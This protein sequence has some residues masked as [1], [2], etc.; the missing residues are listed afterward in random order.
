MIVNFG[1]R[2][3]DADW[4]AF[5]KDGTLIAFEVMWG[6]LA[7]AWVDRL[8]GG[9]GQETLWQE[10]YDSLGYDPVLQ[11][12]KPQSPLAIA[13]TGELHTIMA[14]TLYRHGVSWPDAHERVRLAMEAGDELALADLVEPAGDV[15]SLFA[16][17]HDAGVRVAVVTTDARADT[18]ETLRLLGVERLVDSVVC[19]DDGLVSKPAPD[20]LHAASEGLGQDVIRC[21]V[22]G[23]TLGDLGMAERA[24]A[25][26]RVAVLTGA[27]D[28]TILAQ[29]A[30]V[31]LDSIDD[32]SVADA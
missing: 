24:G 22:V 5:D 25:G 20:M 28:P 19:G 11:R 9:A 17:L 4:V 21:A 13:T 14:V 29:H 30:D 10:L 16:H 31:V 6:R 3:F 23:D 8:A 32:I 2:P 27:G 18:E 1:D 12:T 15:V 7:E 26:L